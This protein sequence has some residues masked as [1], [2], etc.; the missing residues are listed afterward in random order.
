MDQGF[1]FRSAIF[2]ILLMALVPPCFASSQT[3]KPLLKLNGG[4]AFCLSLQAPTLLSSNKDSVIFYKDLC[5]TITVFQEEGDARA[6]V[7]RLGDQGRRAVLSGDQNGV[8]GVIDFAAN[9][10]PEHDNRLDW[11]AFEDMPSLPHDAQP[12]SHDD[13]C[14]VSECLQIDTI[15][16]KC[17][18][19]VISQ[20][21]RRLSEAKFEL[22]QEECADER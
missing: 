3:D 20:D 17:F 2:G 5:P 19:D 11:L 8:Y 22:R 18:V 16:L 10:A 4:E 12:H 9:R 14:N 13:P 1:R 6:E 15:V 7:K 21:P